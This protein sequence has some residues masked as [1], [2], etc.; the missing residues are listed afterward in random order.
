MFANS[1]TLISQFSYFITTTG[2]L[3]SWDNIYFGRPYLSQE[4][5]ILSPLTYI[6]LSFLLPNSRKTTATK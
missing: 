4:S 2:G 1:L 3:D 6:I 5:I